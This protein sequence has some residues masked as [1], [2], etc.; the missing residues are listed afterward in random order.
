MVAAASRPWG[1]AVPLN[2]AQIAAPVCVLLE[3]SSRSWGSRTPHS[4]A[5][6]PERF[7]HCRETIPHPSPNHPTRRLRKRSATPEAAPNRSDTR[8]GFGERSGMRNLVA[9][10]DVPAPNHSQLRRGSAPGLLIIAGETLARG[11]LLAALAMQRVGAGG[12]RWVLPHPR[13]RASG[14]RDSSGPGTWGTAVPPAAH[15]SAH[16][17]PNC[18]FLPLPRAA[19]LPSCQLPAPFR[20]KGAA[21]PPGLALG[22]EQGVTLCPLGSRSAGTCRQPG[23]CVL[24]GRGRTEGKLWAAPPSKEG[25]AQDHLQGADGTLSSKLLPAGPLCPGAAEP[26]TRARGVEAPG[27]ARSSPGP[28]AGWGGCRAGLPLIPALLPTGSSPSIALFM[29]TAAGQVGSC[30]LPNMDKARGTALAA[31]QPGPARGSLRLLR[32]LAR[33]RRPRADPLGKGRGRRAGKA[34]AARP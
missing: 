7:G 33:G 21:C 5:A 6:H 13:T 12:C 34:R 3:P 22:L 14:G 4:S 10:P 19:L 11:P 23:G 28:A 2:R 16:T 25:R 24:Q 27:W 15:F 17:S 9:R 26:L 20:A 18:L 1:A 32:G 30:R 31:A 8:S 29:W